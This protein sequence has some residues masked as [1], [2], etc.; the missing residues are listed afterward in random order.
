MVEGQFILVVVSSLCF[1]SDDV[2]EEVKM[3]VVWNSLVAV[4]PSCSPL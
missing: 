1:T 4:A 2:N 3:V